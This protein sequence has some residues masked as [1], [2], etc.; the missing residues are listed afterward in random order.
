MYNTN[1][2]ALNGY[3]LEYGMEEA[4]MSNEASD[5]KR[6]FSGKVSE[7]QQRK[8]QHPFALQGYIGKAGAVF[9]Q[10]V[11]LLLVVRPLWAIPYEV[12]QQLLITGIQVIASLYG[13][14]VTGYI[15]FMGNQEQHAA[16]D[17]LLADVVS[18]MKQR[19]YRYLV[20][21]TV[22]LIIT[23]CLSA[24]ML[25]CLN[26]DVFPPIVLRFLFGETLV[27]MLSALYMILVAAVTMLD[28]KLI[29]KISVNEQN[30]LS[31][32]KKQ[33]DYRGFMEDFQAIERLIRE[34]SKKLIDYSGE[35]TSVER[36][37]NLLNAQRHLDYNLW[38][39]LAKLSQFN[40]FSHFSKRERV[41]EDL[42]VLAKECLR[43]LKNKSGEKEDSV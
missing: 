23:L 31:S 14:I 41:P 25:L 33:G 9:I 13:L 35:K 30:E 22:Y 42:C 16:Q 10:I 40:S 43:Q 1:D 27:G 38:R 32:E 29:E 3:M 7:F 4:Y 34:Q 21:S 20:F 17:H 6:S 5:D 36:M 26:G 19:F 39:D 18:R 24:I 8:Q 12:S 15:F 11:T 37:A 2:E 28:P